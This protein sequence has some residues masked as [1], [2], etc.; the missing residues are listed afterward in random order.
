MSEIQITNYTTKEILSKWARLAK[1]IQQV[2]ALEW[3]KARKKALSLIKDREKAVAYIDS[4][5]SGATLPE[6]KT[7]SKPIKKENQSKQLNWKLKKQKRKTSTDQTIFHQNYLRLLKIAP[8]LEERLLNDEEVYGKSKI[9]G[10]MEFNLEWLFTE[11]EGVYHLAMSHYY[12]Q[13]GDMV[14]DPDMR[15]LVNVNEEYIKALAYQDYIGY[16]QVYDD[17]IDRNKINLKLSKSLNSFLKTW[18]V[19]LINQHQIVKWDNDTENQKVFIPQLPEMKIV[20]DEQ[21]EL[22]KEEPKK[23]EH[24]KSKSQKLREVKAIFSKIYQKLLKLAP[25]LIQ[26]LKKDEI[27]GILSNGKSETFDL[28]PAIPLN[29]TT[30]RFGINEI[31]ENGKSLIVSVNVRS[32]RAWVTFADKGFVS[33]YEYSN[34]KHELFSNETDLANDTFESW[35]FLL[36]DDNYKVEWNDQKGEEEKI[37]TKE[38][39]K[40]A[41]NTPQPEGKVKLTDRH[42]K[43]GFKQKH[44]DW[45][46]KHRKGLVLV[47]RRNIA[48]KTKDFLSDLRK[49]AMKP[50]KRISRTG[51]I[52]YEGRSNRSDLT[53]AGL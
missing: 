38:D 24:Q 45:I 52:Y 31:S 41:P 47:V 20:K 17:M 29:T 30:F 49:T 25:D 5:R 46:N 11:D 51:V 35:L 6:S 9:P 16:Q 4:K 33:D 28:V 43:A 50:G 53:S 37:E 44:I 18:L 23:Q 27:D 32:K 21:L 39:E 22:P 3:E 7:T 10:M 2:E 26:R 36:L 48:N 14:P 15:I 12:K 42:I 34:E 40:L 1:F 13:N 8:G 19:N